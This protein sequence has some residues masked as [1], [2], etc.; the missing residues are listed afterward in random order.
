MEE[1]FF[2]IFINDIFV[3]GYIGKFNENG[4]IENIVKYQNK[5]IIGIENTNKI[6]YIKD[7]SKK[8]ETFRNVIMSKDYF[9][10]L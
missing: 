8:L 7:I 2:G 10:D 3:E 4:E 6:N 1:I 9:G 5:K